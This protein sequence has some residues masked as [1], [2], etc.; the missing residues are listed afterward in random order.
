MNAARLFKEMDSKILLQKATHQIKRQVDNN[1][2]KK[3]ET[4]ADTVRD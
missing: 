4:N 1:A 2:V 3:Q